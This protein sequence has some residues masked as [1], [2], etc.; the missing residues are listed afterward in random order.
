MLCS[1]QT[2]GECTDRCENACRPQCGNLTF[3]LGVCCGNAKPRALAL[4]ECFITRRKR[5]MGEGSG[6]EGGWRADSLTSRIPL[7]S[8]SVVLP[9]ESYLH[10]LPPCHSC[11]PSFL[12]PSLSP[13]LSHF[14]ADL[15]TDVSSFSP[16]PLPPSMPAP[17]HQASFE[18]SA[19]PHQNSIVYRPAWGCLRGL[20][21]KSPLFPAL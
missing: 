4:S 15:I 12:S 1:L 13:S 8:D 2:E 7:G 10:M 21:L 14:N 19:L 16:P 20:G 5:L 6:T 9:A 3:F 18:S 17:S 11:S